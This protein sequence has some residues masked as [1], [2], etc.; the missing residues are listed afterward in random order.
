MPQNKN[1]AFRVGQT[2]LHAPHLGGRDGELG[3]RAA[4]RT[5]PVC[6]FVVPGQPF[7]LGVASGDSTPDGIVWWTR[8]APDPA[9]FSNLFNVENLDVPN[10][11]VT[12]SAFD[13]VT[14]TQTVDQAGP[15]T[16]QL[17]LRYTF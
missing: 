17:S 5:R 1:P 6:C 13:R 2:T 12:S 15:R 9:A 4:A 7:T 11:N 10:T 8:L 14:A 3:A 16:I